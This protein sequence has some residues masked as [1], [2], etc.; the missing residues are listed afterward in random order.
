[1]VGR[2]LQTYVDE[3]GNIVGLQEFEPSREPWSFAQVLPHA[4]FRGL[5]RQFAVIREGRRRCGPLTPLK[6][7][8]PYPPR[9]T[10][11]FSPATPRRSGRAVPSLRRA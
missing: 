11:S 2:A 7:S 8:L 10:V 1:V 4:R 5:I 3:A 9:G 6:H